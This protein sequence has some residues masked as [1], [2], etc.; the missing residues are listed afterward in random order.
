MRINV[1]LDPLVLVWLVSVSIGLFFGY[2]GIRRSLKA[3]RD[4]H[5]LGMNGL[6]E[7]T[8]RGHLV[9]E[10]GRTFVQ[11]SYLVIGLGALLDI[12]QILHLAGAG[13][14]I[15]EVA[16]V[17]NSWVDDRNAV[18]LRREI[19]DVELTVAKGLMHEHIAEE[20]AAARRDAPADYEKEG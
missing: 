12:E 17:V 9:R 7:A 14:V 5:V 2:R 4:M 16:M 10:F 3:L 19:R 15:S 18:H 8:G 6:M 13:L 1:H 11:T 20:K